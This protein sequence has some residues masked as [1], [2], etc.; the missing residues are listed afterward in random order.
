MRLTFA[1]SEHKLENNSRLPDGLYI[2]V[3]SFASAANRQNLCINFIVI[4]YIYRVNLTIKLPV[5]RRISRNSIFSLRFCPGVTPSIKMYILLRDVFLLNENIKN[6]L[7]YL[8]CLLLCNKNAIIFYKVFKP[9]S[10][11]KLCI[12]LGTS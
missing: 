9:S 1:L 4:K 6:K 11:C 7:N 5:Y 2:F 3:Y 8:A 12:T 10:I